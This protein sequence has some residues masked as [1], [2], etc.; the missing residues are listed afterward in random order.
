MWWSASATTLGTAGA[1]G[2]GCKKQWGVGAGR[3]PN[4]QRAVRTRP[5]IE[6]G[7]KPHEGRQHTV[8][9]FSSGWRRWVTTPRI[10]VVCLLHRPLPALPSI[11]SSGRWRAQQ[12]SAHCLS[13][14]TRHDPA[15]RA[16]APPPHR[17]VWR[18]SRHRHHHQGHSQL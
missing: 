6:N 2:A 4:A 9:A 17:R 15:A 10:A 18:L 14:W 3:R 13:E 8:S 1:A 11:I 16:R 5:A 7:R 12:C